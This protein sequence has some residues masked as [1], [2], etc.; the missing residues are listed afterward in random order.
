MDEFIKSFVKKTF[1][2]IFLLVSISIAMIFLGFE[3]VKISGEKTENNKSIF[4]IQKF[5]LVFIKTYEHNLKGIVKARH[6]R[7]TADD[8]SLL[9]SVILLNDSTE[10]PIITSSSE[11][12]DKVKFNI[13][14]YNDIS[15]FLQDKN[16]NTFNKSY[17]RINLFLWIGIALFVMAIIWLINLPKIKKRLIEEKQEEDKKKRIAE[18]HKERAHGLK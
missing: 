5:R 18:F 13:N 4:T 14:I 10:F 11:D 6:R 3:T 1:V 9:S 17:D 16:R 15:F 7:D 8:K 12:N 2:S